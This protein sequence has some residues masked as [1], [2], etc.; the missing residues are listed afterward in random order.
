MK[1]A[2]TVIDGKPV[3]CGENLQEQKSAVKALVGKYGPG[4]RK[5]YVIYSSQSPA[6]RKKVD[7][8]KDLTPEEAYAEGVAEARKIDAARNKVSVQV[9]KDRAVVQADDEKRRAER[10][11]RAVPGS[12]KRDVKGSEG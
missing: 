3:D 11:K 5:M 7:L 1:I 6:M 10:R 9:A 12:H 8:P 4:L 2:V